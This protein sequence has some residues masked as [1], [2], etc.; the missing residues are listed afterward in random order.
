M[1]S[2]DKFDPNTGKVLRCPSPDSTMRGHLD[3]QV[4]RTPQYL[5]PALGLAICR[6][7]VKATIL[8]HVK[9]W[10][11]RF[12]T[13]TRHTW[14]VSGLYWVSSANRHHC[15]TY[16]AHTLHFISP[17]TYSK[18]IDIVLADGLN[19]VVR[20]DGFRTLMNFMGA[21]GHVMHG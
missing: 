8:W 14:L 15:S 7:A 4:L 11:C 20:L 2:L 17:C 6:A 3:C 18:A 19:T 21:V 1:F 16:Q 9:Y 10:C 13:S 12:W 5:N